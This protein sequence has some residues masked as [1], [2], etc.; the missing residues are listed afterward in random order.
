MRP[1]QWTKNVLVVAAPLAAG[2]LGSVSVV[3][4]TGLA[5]LSFCAISS[6]GYAVNDVSDREVDRHHPL[7]QQRP[8]A[9]GA[10]SP[11]SAIGLAVVLFVVALVLAALASRQ[12]VLLV[13]GY[14]LLQI[15]YSLW[16]KHEPVV[17]LATVSA[18]FLMRAVAGGVA[19]D[20]R[21]SQW[22]LLVAGFGSLFVVSGK[23]YSELHT[24]GSE[25]GTRRS[26][27]RYTPTYLRFVWGISAAAAVMSYSLWAFEMERSTGL[28][29]HALSIAP[30]VMAL[31]RYAV[32][33]DAG[34]AAE[35]EDIIWRD[36]PLQLIGLAWLVLVCLGVLG[37]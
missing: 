10:L 28:P 36:R 5:F 33:I 11:G 3:V 18:G 16:F 29:W 27:I 25:A 20:L 17:D 2:A 31:L 14:A 21:I 12:L 22:F 35:P 30:F 7:K 26:L 23:R 13:L 15:G 9:S 6:A 24:L 4:A 19:A 34:M 32:D 8:V 37:A 1:K